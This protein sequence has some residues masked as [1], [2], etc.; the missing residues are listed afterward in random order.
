MSVVLA[1]TMA[2]DAPAPSAP[3]DEVSRAM[4]GALIREYRVI[5]TKKLS[6]QEIGDA[7]YPFLGPGR[8]EED[9]EKARA[10]LEEAYREKGFQTVTVQIPRQRIR[11]GVV[12]LQ[13][14][15]TKVGQLSVK[16]SRYFSLAEIKRRAPSLAPGS[17]P[18]FND[19]TREIVALNG[20]ADLRVTPEMRLGAEPGT[21]D[22]DLVVKDTPPLHGSIELN[23]RYNSGTTPL[24]VNGSIS[25]S[26]LW[27]RGHAAGFSFQLA[28][29]RLDDAA[30][31][32]GFYQARFESLPGLSLVLSATKQDSDVSTL[33]GVAVAGRGIV[34]GARALVKLPPREQFF[35]T[36]SV[37]LDYKRFDEDV[38]LAGALT[39]AP[40]EYYPVSLGYNASW[41]RPQSTTELGSTLTLGFRGLGSDSREFETKRFRADGNF[42][43]LRGHLDHTHDLPRGAE[44]HGKVEGQL[45]SAPLI[46]NEQFGGGGLGN[47]RGYLESATLGDNAL[48]GTL[49]L[50]SPSLLR[51]KDG[52]WRFYAFVDAGVLTLRDALPEQIDRFELASVGIG[53]RLRFRE[54]F[55][56]SLDAGYPL[57]GLSPTSPGE[58]LL[59]FRLWADF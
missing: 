58:V 3:E 7:V 52:E 53:S 31:F 27:Q 35:H 46:N 13:V 18:N 26:N 49:E 2:Q 15:E 4:R 41:A 24:R 51:E 55:N 6:P 44:V 57:I 20:Q 40:I 43:Y 17:V 36:L 29:E 28:P 14:S 45:A 5:G 38:T 16:G 11:G 47:A 59:T 12:L 22:V 23:N 50:R 34:V 19:V 48:F 56:G 54:H 37:G 30:I 9:V 32:S 8:T 10:A 1:R 21:V 42:F 25:Y 33:G 39:Q